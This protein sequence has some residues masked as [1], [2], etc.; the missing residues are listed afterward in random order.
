MPDQHFHVAV[1]QMP[2]LPRETIEFQRAVKRK[3]LAPD[4]Q[5]HF[6]AGRDPIQGF[7]GFYERLRGFEIAAVDLD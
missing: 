1:W 3:R 4:D 2:G 6:L 7:H 5:P